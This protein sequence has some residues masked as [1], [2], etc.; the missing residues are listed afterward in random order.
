MVWSEKVSNMLKSLLV[1]LQNEGET[2]LENNEVWVCTICG[3]VYV[4]NVLPEICP[5][6]KVPNFKFEKIKGRN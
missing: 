6:C 2:F 5:V 1:R 4:G 3:F